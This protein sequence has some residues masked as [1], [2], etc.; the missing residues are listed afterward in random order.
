MRYSKSRSDHKMHQQVFYLYM[1]HCE[2]LIKELTGGLFYFDDFPRSSSS[3][4]LV[5]A[6]S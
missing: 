1:Y 5:P 6:M 2:Y 3:L 4:N